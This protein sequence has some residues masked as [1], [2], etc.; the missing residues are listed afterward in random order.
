MKRKKTNGK[1][2]QNQLENVKPR[3]ENLN[4]YKSN[5][6][7]R[8]ECVILETSGLN[9][10]KLGRELSR[11]QQIISDKYEKA[12]EEKNLAIQ[13]YEN[14]ILRILNLLEGFNIEMVKN[15][16]EKTSFQI[17][18]LVKGALLEAIKM[19]GITKMTTVNTGE[20]YDPRICEAVVSIVNNE[21]PQGTVLTIL[22][23]G[24]LHGS[25]VV[26]KAKVEV[27][28]KG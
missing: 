27:S 16:E 4:F 14:L 25:N 15:P 12:E 6:E 23:S 8:E 2:C 5:R 21:L 9:L 1:F 24:Y 19:E 22:S 11:K 17:L 13:A 20:V 7:F 26:R 3:V 18:D 10:I 28:K